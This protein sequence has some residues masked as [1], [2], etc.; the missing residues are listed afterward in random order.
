MNAEV[1][2]RRAYTYEAISCNRRFLKLSFYRQIHLFD[3]LVTLF[4]KLVQCHFVWLGVCCFDVLV[5]VSTYLHS[6][7]KSKQED[8]LTSLI[9]VISKTTV[10]GWL[11]CLLKEGALWIFD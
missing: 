11:S 4:P 1:W 3:K 7:C 5:R 9:D 6:Y 8:V 2:A 10:L